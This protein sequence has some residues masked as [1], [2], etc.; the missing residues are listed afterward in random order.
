MNEWIKILTV[1]IRRR[2]ASVRFLGDGLGKFPDSSVADRRDRHHDVSGAFLFLE[3]NGRTRV[4]EV[5]ILVVTVEIVVRRQRLVSNF[6]L[7]TSPFDTP[8]FEFE[9]LLGGVWRDCRWLKAAI[10]LSS[11]GYAGPAGPGPL[12][13]SE[14]NCFTRLVKGCRHANAR[15]CAVRKLDSSERVSESMV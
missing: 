11:P 1:A 13:R 6:H 15:T 8:T 9:Q 14:P 10:R 3:R 7:S 12:L 5:E 4:G 2:V